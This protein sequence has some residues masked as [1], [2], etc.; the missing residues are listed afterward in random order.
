MHVVIDSLVGLV[1]GL[2]TLGEADLITIGPGSLFTSL[3]T[4]VLVHGIPEAIA[5]SKAIKVYISNLMTQANESLN[6]TASA[7]IRKI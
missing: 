4:N 1:T 7:H 3:I 6:L 2:F 5:S